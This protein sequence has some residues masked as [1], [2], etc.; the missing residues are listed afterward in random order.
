V[1]IKKELKRE[2]LILQDV[3]RVG[4]NRQKAI[5]I[6]GKRIYK[7]QYQGRKNSSSI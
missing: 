2:E 1:S 3:R 6:A 5:I 4:A 7:V